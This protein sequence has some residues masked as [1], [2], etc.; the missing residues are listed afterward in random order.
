MIVG[1][2]SC[3]RDE[4]AS[5]TPALRAF[6]RGLVEGHHAETADELVQ[7]ALVQ[8]LADSHELRGHRLRLNLLAKV[9]TAYRRSLRTARVNQQAA[10]QTKLAPHASYGGNRWPLGRR[11][12]SRESHRLDDMPVEWREV[13]L[14]VTL[15]SLTYVQTAECLGITLNAVILN[16]SRAR[17]HLSVPQSGATAVKTVPRPRSV[18]YLRVVK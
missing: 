3:Y 1:R 16:L 18:P 12:G 2:D 17:E 15:E 13:F 11:V 6:A 4:L 14:L 9:V 7:D 10:A 5:L 8:A